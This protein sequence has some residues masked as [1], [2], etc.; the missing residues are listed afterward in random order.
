MFDLVLAFDVKEES[1]VWWENAALVEHVCAEVEGRK[2]K[3]EHA[4]AF[5]KGGRCVETSEL[6]LVGNHSMC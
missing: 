5:N 1:K 2:K 4:D 3:D 6:R